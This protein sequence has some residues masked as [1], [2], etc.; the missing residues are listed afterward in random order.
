LQ[1]AGLASCT[2]DVSHLQRE[3][4]PEP[5]APASPY[6]FSYGAGRKPGHIDR[7]H[8]E[9]SDGS[10]TIRGAFSYVDPRNEVRTVEYIADEYGFYPSLSHID[11]PPKQTAAVEKATNQHIALF[12]KIAEQNSH[13]QEVGSSVKTNQ[14][15]D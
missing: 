10:G 14:F 12:N 5:N 8:T 11:Q 7:T 2:G 6:A 1:C 15:N 9:V 3:Q 4:A 13:A